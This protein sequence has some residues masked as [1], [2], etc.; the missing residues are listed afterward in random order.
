MMSDS[1][2][3]ARILSADA[4][5]TFKILPRNGKIAWVS[6]SRACLAEPPALSPSTRKISVPG[7]AVAGAIGEL[8]GQP[9]FAGRRLARQLALLPPALAFLGPL[10]DA[11][12][13][14]PRGRR[15]AAQP[16]VEMILDGISRR[17]GRLGEASRSLVWP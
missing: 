7:R 2:W 17:A 4:L 8:A 5:A 1:S 12:Q 10:G 13:Q 3:F 9:Q 16:M 6:R 14:L 11:I 15:I